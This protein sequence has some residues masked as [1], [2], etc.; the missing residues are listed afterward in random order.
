MAG[1]WSQ[2]DFPYLNSQ[3]SRV[4][5][6]STPKYNCL[7][8]AAG[9]DRRW[10]DPNPLYYWP[11][12]VPREVSMD[13]V[14]Q[15]FEQLGFSICVGGTRED[16]FEKIAIFARQSQTGRIPTHAARQLDSG[17]WTSKL[18]AYEDVFHETLDALNGPCYGEVACFMSRR[19]VTSEVSGG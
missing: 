14:L 4:T 11:P 13:A 5:S 16:G 12:G 8:W 18:G 9:N 6:P 3:N 10:W 2:R 15:V 7:A 17:G 1:S 19:R